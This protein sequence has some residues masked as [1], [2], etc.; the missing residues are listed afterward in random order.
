MTDSTLPYTE[1][2]SERYNK[3][4]YYPNTIIFTLVDLNNEKVYI[5]QSYSNM[6]DPQINID[7]LPLLSERLSLPSGWIY[8]YIRLDSDTYLVNN[9]GG[10]ATLVIDDYHNSYQ[11][12]PKDQAEFLYNNII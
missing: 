7:T 8:T 6:I 11:Y 2:T 9:S 10:H 4:I 12:I 5:M 3:S 1:I